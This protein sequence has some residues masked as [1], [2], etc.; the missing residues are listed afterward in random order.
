MSKSEKNGS[1]NGGDRIR[2]WILRVDGLDGLKDLL[3]ALVMLSK[4]SAK[5]W[6]VVSESSILDFRFDQVASFAYRLPFKHRC[7]Q[8]SIPE[9]SFFTRS[10]SVLCDTLL[11]RFPGCRLPLWVLETPCCHA[12]RG[13]RCMVSSF[14]KTKHFGVPYLPLLTPLQQ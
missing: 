2:L 11:Y 3:H 5:C 8:T 10:L 4:P 6:N 1:G 13:S 12:E 7:W 14:I 9:L